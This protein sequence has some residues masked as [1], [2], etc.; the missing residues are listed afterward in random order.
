MDRRSTEKGYVS[1]RGLGAAR[2]RAAGAIAADQGSPGHR[3][4]GSLGGRLPTFKANPHRTDDVEINRLVQEVTPA[5]AVLDVGGGAGRF[6]LPLALRCQH[7][8]VVEPSP[9]MGQS[10]LSDR[11]GGGDRQCQP[12]GEAVGRG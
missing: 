12:G 6:A 2:G 1:H 11:G 10:L 9:S 4:G 8:T 5:T 3:R 7:V